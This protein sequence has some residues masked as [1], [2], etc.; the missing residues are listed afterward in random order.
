V[1]AAVGVAAVVADAEEAEDE[2]MNHEMPVLGVGL[3]FREPFLAELFRHRDRVD[4]LEITADH[5][6]DA[7]P[8][9]VAELDLLASEFPIIPHGLDLSLGSADGIDEDYLSALAEIVARLDPPWWSEHIAFTRAG[10]VSIGHLA[11]LPWTREAV[12]VVVNNV[13]RVQSR[14]RTPLILENITATMIVPPSE[15]DE[16]EFLTAVLDQTGCGLLCDVTNLYTNAVNHRQDLA[17]LLARWPWDRVVQLH[18][19]GG[20]WHDG[21]LLDSHSH[22]TPPEIWTVLGAAVAHAPIR[23]IILERDENLPP[24]SEMLDELEQARTIGRR[25][26]RW[27]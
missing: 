5:Y 22:A 27:A 21:T 17:D 19:A 12:D 2:T 7:S 20:N 24:F 18:F 16:V 8:E 10:G 23:G 9:K 6:M 3:G 14:I 15:M 4:F 26:G 1:A 25:H 11:P 13:E